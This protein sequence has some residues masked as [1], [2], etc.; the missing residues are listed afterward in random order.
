MVLVEDWREREGE[1]ERKKRS[2]N[3]EPKVVLR[4]VFI[5]AFIFE[6]VKREIS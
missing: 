4:Q 6:M 3:M 5:I 2:R 1:R